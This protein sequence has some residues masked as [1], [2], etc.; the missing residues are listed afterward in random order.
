MLGVLFNL[1]GDR[2]EAANTLKEACR[3]APT[4][5]ALWNKLGATLAN[6]QR[7]SE[8]LE[9][10]RRALTIRP[11]YVRLHVNMGICQQVRVGP[12]NG[13]HSERLC[14]TRISKS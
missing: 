6:S 11:R 10:Y 8:A 4:D 5:F 2:E 12:E 9:A 7:H 14:T 13:S 3:L 1:A